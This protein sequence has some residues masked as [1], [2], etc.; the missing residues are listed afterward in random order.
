MLGYTK[1]FK[2][3]EKVVMLLNNYMLQNKNALIHCGS[4]NHI[5]K[6]NDQRYGCENCKKEFCAKC[7]KDHAGRFCETEN[8]NLFQEY[9]RKITKQC[10][11]CMVNIEKD[12]GCNHMTCSSCQTHFC[13]ICLGIFDERIIYDHMNQAHGL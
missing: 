1:L 12:G 2:I 13:W 10:P 7:H 8:E 11:K 5:C 3:N 9:M 6:L 4:C